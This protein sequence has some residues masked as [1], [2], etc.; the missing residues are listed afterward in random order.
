MTYLPEDDETLALY[1][2]LRTLTTRR[3][4]SLAD[5]DPA[6]A[7]DCA[8]RRASCLTALGKRSAGRTAAPLRLVADAA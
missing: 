1:R 2:E 4:A 7:A 6:A 5:G 8:R 3:L